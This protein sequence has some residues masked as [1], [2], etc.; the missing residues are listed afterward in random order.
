[1]GVIW[2]YTFGVDIFEGPVDH[3]RLYVRL[4]ENYCDKFEQQLSEMKVLMMIT[5]QEAGAVL[6]RNGLGITQIREMSGARIEVSLRKENEEHRVVRLEGEVRSVAFAKHLIK[7][8]I[9]AHKESLAGGVSDEDQD[10]EKD[11]DLKTA[12]NVLARIGKI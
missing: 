2:R 7:M 5:T 4:A 11:A 12:A 9:E 8:K 3:I 1:M 10:D 6:G